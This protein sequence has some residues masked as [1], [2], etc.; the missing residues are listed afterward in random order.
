MSDV[1]GLDSGAENVVVVHTRS[2][3]MGTHVRILASTLEARP[4][5][6]GKGYIRQKVTNE[7]IS[8]SRKLSSNTSRCA[9]A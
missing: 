6:T 2:S 4:T 8:P 3:E 9:S 7:T 5:R 1:T